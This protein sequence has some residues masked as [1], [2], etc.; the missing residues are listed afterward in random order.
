MLQKKTVFGPYE[1]IQFCFFR[2]LH[3]TTE[4]NHDTSVSSA[5]TS[6]ELRYRK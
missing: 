1:R 3:S 5:Q 2:T 4:S 6:K